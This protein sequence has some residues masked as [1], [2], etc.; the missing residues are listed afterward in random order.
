MPMIDLNT[1][2][3][4]ISEQQQH[5][6]ELQQRIALLEAMLENKTI[7]DR[8]EALKAMVNDYTEKQHFSVIHSTNTH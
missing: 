4:T 2:F 3:R 5:I 7:F 6:N 8:A 1:M